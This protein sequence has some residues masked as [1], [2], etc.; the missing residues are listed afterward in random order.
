MNYKKLAPV[1]LDHIILKPNCC[2]C[3]N[4]DKKTCIILGSY[5]TILLLEI[6]K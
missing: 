2:T 3:L 5:Q 4:S 6:S 1:K